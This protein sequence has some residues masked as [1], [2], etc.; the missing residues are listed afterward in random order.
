MDSLVE[1]TLATERT[2]MI[3]LGV[4]ALVAILLAAVGL[5][6]VM[7]SIVTQRTN[8]IGVRIAIG[9]KPSDILKMILSR[10]FT[11]TMIGVMI[12]LAGSLA[13]TRMLSS[14]LYGV[15]ATDPATFCGVSLLLV[16]IALVAC[17]LPARRATR[18]DPVVALRYE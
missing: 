10:G 7:S 14:L 17:Y 1:R 11:L 15:G 12:G 16:A 9:A 3:L 5:Y 2:T 18:V 8:E 13:L 4:F 6:G